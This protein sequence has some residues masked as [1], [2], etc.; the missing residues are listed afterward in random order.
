MA[1]Y[2]LAMDC[3]DCEDFLRLGVDAFWWLSRADELVRDAVF[4]GRQPY[5]ADIDEAI[6]LL[7]K[8]WLKPCALADQWIK[9]QRDRN[10]VVD[11]LDEFRR[12]VAEV[13]A[14]V[15]NS[16]EVSGELAKM[17]DSA[18]ASYEGGETD[19]WEAEEQADT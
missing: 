18:I 7:Y 15:R 14:I 10:F 8:T 5:D 17:R 11:G 3:R 9:V 12:C 1:R 2:K 6:A 4:S 19:G 13:T 16:K